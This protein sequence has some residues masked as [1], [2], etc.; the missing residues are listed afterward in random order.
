MET[1][2]IGWNT[3]ETTVSYKARARLTPT[4]TH[5]VTYELVTSGAEDNSMSMGEG[6]PSTKD[7]SA[8]LEHGRR[9]I[10]S[11]P[12]KRNQW[13]PLKSTANTGQVAEQAR[14]IRYI[15]KKGSGDL[16][17]ANDM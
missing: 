7:Y 2:G 11:S 1:N 13:P 17:S 8:C 6:R 16:H 5:V 12:I 9:L 3:L 10:L 14:V 15:T 4:L